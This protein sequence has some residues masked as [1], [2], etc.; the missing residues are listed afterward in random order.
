VEVEKRRTLDLEQVL[1]QF[2]EETRRLQ[3]LVV[4]LPPGDLLRPATLP[5]APSGN[6][7]ERMR[8]NIAVVVSGKCM[9]DRY[10]IGQIRRVT[11]GLRETARPPRSRKK[12]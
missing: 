9:H 2:E 11:A 6:P 1:D 10:H 12:E 5:A 4:A 7:R 8:G 3:D